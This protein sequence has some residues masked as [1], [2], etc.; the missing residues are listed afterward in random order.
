MSREI[1]TIFSDLD[2]RKKY[3]RTEIEKAITALAGEQDKYFPPLP[4]KSGCSNCCTD[5]IILS[6]DDIKPLIEGLRKL[7]DSIRNKI[8]SNLTRASDRC[9]LLID[10]INGCAVHNHGKPLLCQLYGRPNTPAI[11]REPGEYERRVYGCN[12][13]K[14]YWEHEEVK[15][16]ASDGSDH[17]P[18]PE[19]GKGLLA[20]VL[21]STYSGPRITIKNVVESF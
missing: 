12:K 4:C 5:D 3:S 15:Y 17:L 2:P 14:Q 19:M 8:I 18:L 1:P 7:D 9:P 13:C 16:R 6:E 20:I 11:W 10:R 21:W